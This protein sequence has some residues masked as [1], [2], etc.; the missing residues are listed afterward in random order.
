[1]RSPVCTRE[2]AILQDW[3]RLSAA[4]G[5]RVAEGN[6]V[7][8]EQWPWEAQIRRVVGGGRRR[9]ARRGERRRRRGW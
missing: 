7:E 6:L 2:V 9:V 1:M 4:L 5:R 8:G 3:G